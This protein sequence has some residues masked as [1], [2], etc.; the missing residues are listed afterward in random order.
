MA[1]IRAFLA[2]R[3]SERTSGS[4]PSRGHPCLDTIW[5]PLARDDCFSWELTISSLDRHVSGAAVL[6]RAKH[7]AEARG[8][9]RRAFQRRREAEQMEAERTAKAFLKLAV[10]GF[11][12]RVVESSIEYTYNIIYLFFGGS[13]LH[14][15]HRVP[16]HLHTTQ[17]Y[18]I[19]RGL[20]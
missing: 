8:A 14:A 5:T 7:Q 11:S 2:P 16:G 9:R 19:F 12:S 20:H 4:L 17:A 18:Y 15:P 10:G 6:A 3:S 13:I 1:G